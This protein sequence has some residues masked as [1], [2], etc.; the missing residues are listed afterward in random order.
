MLKKIL[1]ATL[2]E[3]NYILQLIMSKTITRFLNC[4]RDRS[5]FLRWSP[6]LLAHER[7]KEKFLNE[8]ERALM[9]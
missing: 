7:P 8:L 9:A 3:W 5:R 6:N 1:R 4:G 2:R